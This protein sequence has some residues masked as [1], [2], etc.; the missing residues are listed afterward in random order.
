MSEILRKITVI[1]TDNTEEHFDAI[2][3]RDKGVHIGRII[4]NKFEPFGFIPHHSIKEICN[5]NEGKKRKEKN[6]V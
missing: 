4:N 1:Y 3:I 5:N 6:F 2:R